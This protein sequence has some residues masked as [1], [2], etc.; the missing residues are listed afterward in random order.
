LRL[1]PVIRDVLDVAGTDG[2]ELVVI[3]TPPSAQLDASLVA[4]LSDLIL[5][6]TRPAILDLRAI[7]GTINVIKGA[8]RRALI[9][10]NACP[11]PR[12]AGEATLTGDARRAVAAFGMPVAP[13]VIVNRVTFSSALLTGLTAGEAEPDGKAAREVR[14]VARGGKRAD[15]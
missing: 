15:S 9:V 6:P 14:A 13:G 10:L 2:V 5:V 12:R 4:G 1:I 3:D 11:P 7:L 8:A